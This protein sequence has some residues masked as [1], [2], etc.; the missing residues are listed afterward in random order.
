MS[1][2]RRSGRSGVLGGLL[3]LVILIVVGGLLVSTIVTIAIWPGQVKLVAPFFCTDAQPD[4]FVVADTYNPRPGETVTNFSLYCMGPRGDA[5]DHGF[6]RPFL[7]TAMLN[8]I[9]LAILVSLLG[10]MFR[11]RR[12]ARVGILEPD[13]DGASEATTPST[14]STPTTPRRSMPGPGSTPG[15]FVD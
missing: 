9:V 4:A 5:T 10:F 8:G 13:Q 1:T 14:P 2:Q 7:V 12:R 3:G 11:R 15:P 6:M